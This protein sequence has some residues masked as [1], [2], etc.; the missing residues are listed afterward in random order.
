MINIPTVIEIFISIFCAVVSG[1]ILYQFKSKKALDEKRREKRVEAEIA[2]RE[3]ILSIASATEVVLKRL[4]NE[5]INGDI[6]E[7]KTNLAE[8]ESTLEKVTTKDFYE[9]LTQE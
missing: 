3:L 6:I 5:K 2:E 9:G 7:A 8:K 1:I 4:N